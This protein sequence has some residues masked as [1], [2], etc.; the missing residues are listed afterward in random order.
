MKPSIGKIGSILTGVSPSSSGLNSGSKPLVQR[1]T[2]F[3]EN[4]QTLR[5]KIKELEEKITKK[6]QE[7]SQLLNTLSL[8]TRL[9][10]NILQRLT[11]AEVYHHN[12]TGQILLGAYNSTSFK[13]QA[14]SL[15]IQQQN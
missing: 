9:F 1:V 8:K 6:D 12:I 7:I 11:S 15:N 13:I 14:N 5:K 10:E 2:N 4:I 3:N